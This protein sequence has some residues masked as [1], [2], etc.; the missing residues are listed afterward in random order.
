M[1]TV[2]AAK[3]SGRVISTVPAGSLEGAPVGVRPA[4]GLVFLMP[5]NSEGLNY[6]R[7]GSVS[8]KESDGSFEISGVPLGAYELFAQFPVEA[9]TGWGPYNPPERASGP[10][11]FGRASVDVRDS[12]VENANIAIHKGT[13][14]KGRLL[15]DGKPA[16]A[17][18]RISLQADDTAIVR[19]GVVART[20][21]YIASFPAPI[22]QDGTFSIPLIPEGQYRFVVTLTGVPAAPPLPALSQNGYVA[23]IRQGG[24]SVYDNGLTVGEQVDPIDILI[25]T[26]PGSLKGTVTATDQKNV[27]GA[28]V[29]LVPQE[30]RRQNPALYR[31]SRSDPQ[32]RFTMANLAPGRY[33]LFAWD[34]VASGAYQN[35]EFF[36]KYSG[37]G[38]SVIIE[39]GARATA[40]VPV[41][42]NDGEKR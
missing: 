20:F 17:N 3:I 15:I 25:S 5:K 40:S 8:A 4:A 19:G 2:P 24:V 9:Y 14:V 26:S 23:D 41:I 13:D 34:D 10:N 7:L 22:A 30:K 35:A 1:R 31:S 27:M 38:V 36:S 12:N 29:V 32:G 18:V 28:A 21:A 33:T 42:R 39:A 37:R 11:A 16:G 6:A